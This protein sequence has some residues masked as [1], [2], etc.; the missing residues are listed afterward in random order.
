MPTSGRRASHATKCSPMRVVRIVAVFVLLAMAVSFA[1]LAVAVSDADQEM[2]LE[3][4]SQTYHQFATGLFVLV[5]PLLPAPPASPTVLHPSPLPHPP[6]AP[7]PQVSPGYPPFRWP[8][9][10]PLPSLPAA[11]P[12]HDPQPRPPQPPPRLPLPAPPQSRPHS[13]PTTRSPPPPVVSL[14]AGENAVVGSAP[15]SPPSPPMLLVWARHAHKNCWGGDNGADADLEHP[16]GSVAADIDTVEDCQRACRG[17]YPQCEGIVYHR[18]K[19]RCYRRGGISI[20]QCHH[21]ESFDLFVIG[22]T[23][24][25]SPPTWPPPPMSPPAPPASTVASIDARYQHGKPSNYLY[26]AG[27]LVHQFDGLED[28]AAGRG[29]GPCHSGWCDG[30][31]D[32]TSFSIISKRYPGVF[33]DAGGVILASYTPIACAYAAD[34]G[35]QSTD[36]ESACSLPTAFG[37]NHLEQM[38]KVQERCCRSHYNEAVVSSRFWAS[39]L[40]FVVEAIFYIS[41][42]RQARL[43]H[44]QFLSEY[45]LEP[46]QCPLLKYVHGSGFVGE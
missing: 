2:V 12:P 10:S 34:G 5:Q 21:S 42:D 32:H 36:I 13:E 38:L 23:E 6:P 17:I 43:A 24:P 7:P 41:D 22:P 26:E 39:H 14:E 31:Y 15:V 27:V 3:A 18:T 19:N 25:P 40:P 1:T 11:P 33:N 45:D 20:D 9:F 8:P 44:R 28:W 46:Q 37:P 30:R 35:T 16:S 29:F 4:L